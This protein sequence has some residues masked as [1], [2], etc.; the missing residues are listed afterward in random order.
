MES[1]EN[2]IILFHVLKQV[3]EDNT[4][5]KVIHTIVIKSYEKKEVIDIS[6]LNINTMKKTKNILCYTENY[7]KYLGYYLYYALKENN[8]EIIQQISSKITQNLIEELDSFYAGYML[9]L[10][11][12]TENIMPF[13]YF[14][15]NTIGEDFFIDFR[16]CNLLIDDINNKEVLARILDETSIEPVDVIERMKKCKQITDTYYEDLLD[17]TI[18]YYNIK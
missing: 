18:K 7:M 2:Q 3:E 16:L 6:S 11:N 15:K 12:N 5:K 10:K 4:T 13:I 9:D 1:I 14:I 8:S 17:F